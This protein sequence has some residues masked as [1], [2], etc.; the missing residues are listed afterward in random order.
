LSLSPPGRIDASAIAR[1]LRPRSVAI[2][3]AS[4]TPGALGASVLANL[5]RL[6]FSG[7]IHLINP[8]R[9][10][11]A[12]RPCL[13]SVEDLPEGV[14][15]AVLAIPGAAVLD[16]I[17]S[18]AAR[19]V[20]AAI[21]FSA[22]FAEGGA[23]G[24]LAQGEIASIAAASG[25]VI[26][27]P[28]CLGLVN[29]VDGI[30]LT[31][32]ETPAIKLEGRPGI[33]IVSQS[34]AM[35]A[36]LS[37]MLTSRELGLSY[38][39]STGNEAASGVEHYVDY[40]LDDPHTQV[41]GMIVEQFR[42]PRRFLEI[43]ERARAR[44]KVIV[45]L[46]PGRSAAARESAATH[47]GALAG[48]YA[49]MRTK[50]QR[51]GVVLAESL[52]EL[53]DVLE[54]ATR[55]PILP[56]GGA[57]IVTESGA[58]KA[59]TLDLCEQIGLPLPTLTDQNSPVL[60][61]AIP[62]FVPVSNPLD[63]TAQA[64]V[65]PDLYRRTLAAL[66]D[67]E[68]FGSIVLGIIQTDEATSKLKFPPIIT[69]IEALKP[70][71]PLVFAGL[72]EGANVP[73]E[74]I[75]GLRSL[76]VPYF[77]SPERALR[78]IARL[79][80][81]T[82]RPIA[83]TQTGVPGAIPTLSPGVI[84]EYLAKELLSRTGIPFPVGRFVRTLAEGLQAA[85]DIGY[86]LVLKAQ[87]PELS[88]KSDSGGVVLNLVDANTLAA[89]WE[90]LH[91]NVGQHRPELTLDGVLMERMS[92]RGVELIIGIRNE[93]DWGGVMVVGFGGVQAEILN[94]VRLLTPDM[95]Q[96]EITTEL[97]LLKSAALLR[98]FRGHPPRLS[99]AAR[100]LVLASSHP[101]QRVQGHHALA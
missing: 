74:Y 29:Y 52:E 68:R 91:A 69:A 95:T 81:A 32:V 67:D 31:F 49:L 26:E 72:D 37:V 79:S 75:R 80:A 98:G 12:G 24:L 5:E 83:S 2:V 54:L 71:K 30:A 41:V 18:L 97:L 65:D 8:K 9:S 58:F 86:P 23:A 78:A 20:G 45:L 63:L 39:I 92:P 42:D 16:T 13:K 48:D 3:G 21:I 73:A 100:R 38:S 84:P 51:Q 60:R 44:G 55:C 53:G 7:N 96:E 27:G 10:E 22:G 59:L 82:S 34:G 94:D 50:V 61:A 36:V 47:T 25:M 14:D 93:P 87:S 99:I 88:H 89:G 56:T 101:D 1:L 64:L 40:L 90:K 66:T 17:R 62:T 57:V 46:H 15:V 70:R 76:S 28:N 35:A 43:A 4:P 77:S 85:N 19:R 6:R 33:A 11:I